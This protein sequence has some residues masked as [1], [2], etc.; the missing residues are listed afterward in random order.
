MP[1]HFILPAVLFFSYHT[2]STKLNPVIKNKPVGQYQHNA[3]E[4]KFAQIQKKYDT[5]IPILNGFFITSD[6][7][8][9]GTYSS[10]INK[11]LPQQPRGKESLLA[12]IQL[13]SDGPDG[14]AQNTMKWGVIDSAGN[15]IVPFIC[16][17]VREIE[18]NKGIFS[19]YKSSRSLNTG[20]PRYNYTG[21]YYFFDKKGI[22]Q[23]AGKLFTITTI[24]VADFH[25]AKFV[26]EQG[27]TFYLPHPYCITN[28]KARGGVSKAYLEDH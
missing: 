11:I 16:D 19:I 14:F 7:F 3:I 20:L 28:K 25:Q 6:S 23:T 22:E 12:R 21:Y 1:L 17:A 18:N 2:A 9:V 13:F 4:S 5:L 24:F 26:I 27:N 15:I 10:Y 8:D